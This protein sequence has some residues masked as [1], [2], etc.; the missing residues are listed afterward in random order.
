MDAFG[1]FRTVNAHVNM[2][3]YEPEIQFK[4]LETWMQMV[5]DPGEYVKYH[6]I[7]IVGRRDM[8]DYAS[9]V[10]WWFLTMSMVV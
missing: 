8:I 7:P 1:I 2:E 9:S 5:L 6:S 3:Q 4:M 10:L